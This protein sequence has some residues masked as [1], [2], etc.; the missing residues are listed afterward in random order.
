MDAESDGLYQAL[1]GRKIIVSRE[2]FFDLKAPQV[3]KLGG[4]LDEIGIIRDKTTWKHMET[5]FSKVHKVPVVTCSTCITFRFVLSQ[6]QHGFEAKFDAYDGNL[7]EKTCA[8][9]SAEL[10][11]TTFCIYPL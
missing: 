7:E 9:W 1:I 6:L 8:K 11:P 5:T 2:A 4:K 3:R 10:F